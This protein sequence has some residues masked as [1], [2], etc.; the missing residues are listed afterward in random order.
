MNNEVIQ[1]TG[2]FDIEPVPNQN[3]AQAAF[4]W[5]ETFAETKELV[6]EDAELTATIDD[7]MVKRFHGRVKIGFNLMALQKE[8]SKNGYGDFTTVIL[9]DLGINERFAQRCI[10]VARLYQNSMPTSLSASIFDLPMP[11]D[12]WPFRR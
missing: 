5:D 12:A 9:P 3:I 7:A 11:M 8:H 4:N 10:S 2:F 1:T 6:K